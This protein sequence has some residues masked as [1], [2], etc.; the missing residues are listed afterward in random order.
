MKTGAI[1]IVRNAVDLAPLTVLHHH[2]IGADTVWVTDNGSSD[3]TYEVLREIAAKIPGL[4]V[5]RDDGPF[6]QAR[7]ATDMANSLLRE[8]HRL[9]V[10][11]DSDECWDLSIP[12]L[13]RFMAEQRV[14]AVTGV[15]VNYVQARSVL[16]PTPDSWRSANRRVEQAMDPGDLRGSI[17]S[18]RHS[19]VQL[20]FQRK[21]LAAPPAGAEVK[22]G[23]GAHEIRFEGRAVVPW[24][25]I[26]CLHLPLRAASELEK[27]VRDY[28]DRHA[29]FRQDPAFGWR[30]NYWSE[31]V[32]SGAIEQEWAANSYAPDGTLDVF[33]R[34]APTV[35]DDRLVRYLRR[36]DLFLNAMRLPG[37]RLWAMPARALLKPRFASVKSP[38]GVD[39][40]QQA[41]QGEAT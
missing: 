17:K 4:R 40:R 12:R 41:G 18:K 27:R 13:R 33:G 26:A 3:G 8:G 25:R 15:V 24:R 37:G 22:I 11:F 7:M 23:K 19:F 21:M 9:I 1:A 34:P 29:P 31:M 30:L 35:R 2:L 20:I 39:A 6:D 16:V 14:N 10:P 28:K 36:A 32:A 5:D 38:A